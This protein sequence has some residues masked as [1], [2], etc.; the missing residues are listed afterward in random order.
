M[1][2]TVEQLQALIGNGRAT[3]ALRQAEA[4]LAKQDDPAIRHEQARAFMRL[5]EYGAAIKAL[6]KAITNRPGEPVG[7]LHLGIAYA[8]TGQPER[9]D[10][11]FAQAI[12][13]VPDFAYAIYWRAKLAAEAKNFALAEALFAEVAALQPGNDELLL[14]R[15]NLARS[16]CDWDTVARLRAQ[17]QQQWQ[18]HKSLNLLE[19]LANA[20]DLEDDA[21]Q[22][23][24]SQQRARM[25]APQLAHEP[26]TVWPE[27]MAVA[28]GEPL[29]I[30]YLSANFRK[31]AGGQLARGLF[32]A[33]NRKAVHVTA[34]AL[35]PIDGSKYAKDPKRDA[36]RFV[37]LSGLSA[38]DAAARIRSD[39][40][41]ILIDMKG[42]TEFNRQDILALRPAPVQISYLGYASPMIAP[43]IDYQIADPS[44]VPRASRP[45]F[46]AGLIYLPYT[47]QVN[48]DAQPVPA[49]PAS[50]DQHGLPD[51]A[52]V[53]ASVNGPHKLTR[54]IF[55]LWLSVLMQRPQAVLW[56]FISDALI[57]Q[58]LHAEAAKAGVA[59]ERIIFGD[60]IEREAHLERLQ[61]ANLALDCRPYGG[62]TST[63]DCL[64]AGVPV[65][66]MKGGHFASRVAEGLL[67][68]A[69]VDQLVVPDAKAYVRRIVELIDDPAP[70]EPMREY[71]RAS[72][73]NSRLFSTRRRA[74]ELEQGYQQAWKRFRQGQKPA[75][76]HVAA[77]G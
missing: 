64:W 31:Q 28:E 49:T 2:A 58:R 74:G 13:L 54:E 63:S 70:L 59:A 20:L 51:D 65:I 45:A 73:S 32:G 39:G 41:Q 77:E 52:F 33:H 42:W 76:I 4:I 1:N 30:G 7:W 29:R 23:E 17:A 43:W 60:K 11:A 67:H 38:A 47:Y 35:P 46:P 68:A 37:D 40:I 15:L 10:E 9:A 34:Y 26:Y 71:L 36:D 57:R 56:C 18:R 48:D 72:R 6:S 3:E 21:A 55:G 69:G 16:G 14:A 53:L 66:T 50:R 62:H 8:N 75:D 19:A 44:L 12:K 25:L 27:A 24:L 61:H 22:A 5:R